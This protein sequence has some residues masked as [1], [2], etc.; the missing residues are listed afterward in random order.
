MSAAVTKRLQFRYARLLLRGDS[1]GFTARDNSATRITGQQ[2]PYQL[3]GACRRG[4][5]RV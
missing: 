2:S 5:C 3:R 1:A 4:S